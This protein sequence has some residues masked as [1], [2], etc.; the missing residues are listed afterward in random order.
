MSD[1]HTAT[2]KIVNEFERTTQQA[3]SAMKSVG[4]DAEVMA[5]A[6]K[7][8]ASELQEMIAA[9]VRRKPYQALAIAA[10]VGFVFGLTC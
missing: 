6:A 2:A 8:K 3:A 5:D 4:I 1:T 9:E 7:E 10:V